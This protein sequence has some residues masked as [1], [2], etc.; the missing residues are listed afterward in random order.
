VIQEEMVGAVPWYFDVVHGPIE[1]VEGFWQVPTAPGL[2]IEVD[3]KEC[4]RHPF[5]PEAPHTVNAVL[6]DGT[7]VDW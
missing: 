1:M 6:D 5:E 3:M 2:G 7:I 4:A